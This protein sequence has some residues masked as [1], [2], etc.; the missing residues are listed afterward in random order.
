[1]MID[2]LNKFLLDLTNIIEI[3]FKRKLNDLFY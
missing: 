2:F 1:M 3:K